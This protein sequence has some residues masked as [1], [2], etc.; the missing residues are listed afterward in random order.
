MF[1]FFSRTRDRSSGHLKDKLGQDLF[2]FNKAVEHGFPPKPSAIAHDAVLNLL[3]VGTSNG[4][5]KIYGRPGVEL[6]ARHQQE[7]VIQEL[8]FLPEQ[9]RIISVCDDGEQNTIH[10]WEVNKKEGKSVLEEVKT[11]TLEGRLKKISVCCLSMKTNRLY[12]GT[13]GGN[14]Y[15]LDINSFELQEYIIYQDVV[16]Q[17]VQEESKTNAGSVEAIQEHPEDSNKI[18]IGYKKGLI[19]LWNHERCSVQATFSVQSSDQPQ[20]VESVSWHSDGTTFISAHGDGSLT[21]WSVEGSLEIPKAVTPLGPFPCKAIT[22]VEWSDSSVFF[23]GG[24]PRA[25]YGDRHCVSLIQDANLVEGGDNT[26]QVAFDFTSRV[27]DFFTVKANGADPAYLVVLCEEELVV[28]DLTTKEAG[29]PTFMKPYLVCLHSSPITCSYHSHDCPQSLF[30]QILNAGKKQL[31]TD[32][33]SESWPITGGKPLV[34]GA[35]TKDLLIT[36]HED[37]SINFWDVSQLEMCL[38]YTLHTGK[39]FVGEHEGHESEARDAEEEV[40]PP[41]KKV[42]NYCPYSDDPR[43]AVT[44]IILSSKA[45][46]LTVAGNGGQVLIFDL[47]EEETSV[48]LQMVEIDFTED[49]ENFQWKG[50]GPLLP[51]EGSITVPAGFKLQAGLQLIPAAPVSA[52]VVETRWGLLAAG[53]VHGFILYDYLNKKTVT[54]KWTVSQE[55]DSGEHLSRRKSLKESIRRSFRRL[56]SRKGSRGGAERTPRKEGDAP[57]SPTPEAVASPVSRL[58]EENR[59]DESVLSMVRCLYFVDTFVRDGVH[60]C[61]S[62]WAGTNAGHIYVC[63]LTIP[64]GEKRSEKEVEVEI[65]KEIKLKH[66]A[67]VVSM[68]VVDKD[69]MPLLGD[70]MEDKD[71]EPD[72]SGTHS[73]VICSEEQ[74][75]VFSLPHLKARNKEKLTAI[76]GSRVRKIGLINVRSKN[77]DSGMV[78]H[79]LACVSNQ[80]DLIVYSIPNLKVQVKA[81]AMKKS[82]V[83]AIRSLVFSVSGQGFYLS[84]RSEMQRFTLSATDLLR[85]DCVLELAEG[86]RP[87]EPEPEV[88]AEEAEEDTKERKSSTSSSSSSSSSSD[89]EKDEEKK[90]KKKEKKEKKKKEKGAEAVIEAAAATAVA[91]EVATEVEEK[92]EEAEDKKEEVEEKK[93]EVEEKKDEVEEKADDA[94]MVIAGGGATVTQIVTEKRTYTHQSSSSEEKGAPELMTEEEGSLFSTSEMSSSVTT[95]TRVVSSKQV[96]TSSSTTQQIIT[97]EGTTIEALENG[98]SEKLMLTDSDLQKAAEDMLNDAHDEV[99]QASS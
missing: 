81:S 44:K 3:A 83:D 56:R 75:K 22:K 43:F 63:Y 45:K 78:Y 39:Y 77:D 37:G 86:M 97:S 11:C 32:F 84:S 79:C 10:L 59:V 65:G 42:G 36:G 16:M 95:T 31:Q 46:T 35:D 30:D 9:G 74:F 19:V 18:L 12:L 29:F 67:P 87:P 7:T 88:V 4:L 96:F 13:E 91:A 6:S 76:D 58:V 41:F 90:Q 48:E 57:A 55:T 61:P 50:H 38:I 15:L 28:I 1:K 68:F 49:K 66:K 73:L 27:V 60:H 89:D 8:H 23:S 25:S 94:A 17:S 47:S 26:P 64:E 53:T 99:E 21:K 51:K 85:P 40:W 72:M 33:S 70:V 92:K 62:L 98:E 54:T 69:G 82:D 2:L 80:G 52:L 93:E 71:K 20:E 14:I 5:L 34:E 24:M